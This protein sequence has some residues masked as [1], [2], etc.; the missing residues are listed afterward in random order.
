[1]LL[2]G[3]PLVHVP[4]TLVLCYMAM[5]AGMA[6]ITHEPDLGGQGVVSDHHYEHPMRFWLVSTMSSITVCCCTAVQVRAEERSAATTALHQA[7]E[8]TKQQLAEKY[9]Q[10]AQQQ[11]SGAP[12]LIPA[13]ALPS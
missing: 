7:I 12:S 2:A 11:Q 10:E 3:G 9:S 1:M 6:S 4:P 13:G 5:V 8:R